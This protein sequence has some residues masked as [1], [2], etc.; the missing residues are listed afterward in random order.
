MMRA[1]MMSEPQGRGTAWTEERG[2][3]D[4]CEGGWGGG[5]GLKGALEASGEA[6]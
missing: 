2:T 1:G 4:E 6:P 5:W 3:S